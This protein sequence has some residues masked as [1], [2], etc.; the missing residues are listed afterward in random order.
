M[1]QQFTRERPVVVVGG[2]PAGLTAAYELTRRGEPVVV[3]EQDTQVGGLSRTVVHDGFRFDIGGHRFYTKSQ[4]VLDLWREVLGGEFL[5]RPRLSRIYYRGHFFDYP[6]KAFNVLFGLGILTSL[7]VLLSYL[8]ARIR[9]IRPEVSFADWVTN[10]FGHRL[11]HIFFETYTEKVWGIPPRT[12]GAQWAAQRIKGLSLASAV[13]HMLFPKRGRAAV[14][15]LIEEFEYPRLG[16]GMM[17]EAVAARVEE[18]GGVIA[19]NTGVAALRHDGRRV[20]ALDLETADGRR[21]M[22]AGHVISTMAVRDLM[23]ALDPAPPAPVLA[24]AGRLKYR[25]FLTVAL[26]LD[27]EHLF[28]DNWIYVH[29]ETVKVGRIQNFKNW[30]PE[31]VPDPSQTCLGLEYFCFEGDGLWT[32]DDDA[33]VALATR[34]LVGLGL[35]EA[36]QVAGGAVVRAKKA[37]PVYDEGYADALAVVVDYLSAF[38]NLQLVGRN[39][40]HKYNN[41]DHSMLTAM[42]AV[43]NLYGEQH[44]LWAFN[45]DDEYQEEVAE[46]GEDAAPVQDGRVD[47]AR[48]RAKVAGTQPRVPRPTASARE[49]VPTAAA[50]EG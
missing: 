9:P 43:R 12:I 47:P 44:D 28:P 41:Q 8:W 23:Q 10:R 15:T 11:Y 6:L 24:A 7:N 30:S 48:D 45:T 21:S 27:V 25:D 20:Q 40:M 34:E 35:A 16:P 17:W 38:E 18:A 5:R 32:M 1:S 46:A 26:I 14:K 37:Y 39:G 2:G 4:A 22:P 29:D 3:C 42:L 13:R 50:G 31:M 19:M 36:G 33:L 49:R